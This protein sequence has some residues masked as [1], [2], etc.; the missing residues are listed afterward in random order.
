MQL[1]MGVAMCEAM[2]SMEKQRRILVE[3]PPDGEYHIISNPHTGGKQRFKKGGRVWDNNN[4]C[5]NCDNKMC[6]NQ[7]KALSDGKEIHYGESICKNP[8]NDG[9]MRML[10]NWR[11]HVKETFIE[12]QKPGKTQWKKI[13]V[14]T[15]ELTFLG[16]KKAKG[17]IIPILAAT[18]THVC[19][20]PTLVALEKERAKGLSGWIVMFIAM[21]M[22]GIN[23]DGVDHTWAL[24]TTENA[25]IITRLVNKVRQHRQKGIDCYRF[26]PWE[27]MFKCIMN[28]E[29]IPDNVKEMILSKGHLP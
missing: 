4:P 22:D 11:K 26:T 7:I 15:S 1:N 3:G 29:R 20:I 24:Y 21:Y 19:S 12:T 8:L 16:R 9:L 5:V 14:C 6:F 25:A 28:R 13:N 2:G 27:T 18:T 17:G 10:C 23:H